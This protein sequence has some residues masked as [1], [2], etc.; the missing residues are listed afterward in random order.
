MVL[1]LLVGLPILELFVFI[2]VGEAIGFLEA[3]GLLI[4]VSVLGFYVVKHQGIGVLRRFVVEREAGRIPAAAAAD[5]ALIALAGV[6]LVVPGFV[7]STVGVL[8]LLPPVRAGLRG[9][10]RHRWVPRS[11]ARRLTR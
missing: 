4:L 3:L 8:L 7:T 1:L 5:G 2:Q 6:L 11:V 10:F 9:W